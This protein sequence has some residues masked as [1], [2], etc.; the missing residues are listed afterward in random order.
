MSCLNTTK[1]GGEHK[2][3]NTACVTV[4][5]NWPP[6]VALFG[7]PVLFKNIKTNGKSQGGKFL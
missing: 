6:L 7:C 2:V 3:L 4:K 5:W 1:Q